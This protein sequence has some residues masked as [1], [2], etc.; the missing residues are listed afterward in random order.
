M[1]L[2]D[3]GTCRFRATANGKETAAIRGILPDPK[4]VFRL[5]TNGKCATELLM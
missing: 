1:I 5:T 2:Y 3:P 4:P